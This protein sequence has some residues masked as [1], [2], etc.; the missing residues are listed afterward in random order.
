MEKDALSRFK[1][2]AKIK[3]KVEQASALA[4]IGMSVAEAVAKSALLLP[5]TLGSPLKELHIALGIAQAALVA[6]QKPPA[7][8]LGGD[9]VTQGPQTIMV[10]DNPGGRE[11]VQVT[12]LSSPNINGPQGSSITLN[13]SAPLVDE[14]ILDTIIPAIE[15][16]QRNNL[17]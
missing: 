15:K 8:A 10:G 1:D 9:F 6:S 3:F 4:S 5:A 17:A 12:P 2:E 14:T 11:R 13:V 16:A 7:F